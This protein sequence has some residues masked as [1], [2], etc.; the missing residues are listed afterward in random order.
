M[1]YISYYKSKLTYIKEEEK[2]EQLAY[3]DCL[4]HIY[5]RTKCE[6]LMQELDSMLSNYCI[7]SIDLN[8]LKKINDTKGHSMGDWLLSSFAKLLDNFFSV[9]GHT[10]RIGGDEFILILPDDSKY[11]DIDELLTSFILYVENENKKILEFQYS[12][13][14]GYAKRCDVSSPNAKKVYHLAD[15]RMYENK[16]AMKKTNHP[17]S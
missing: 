4:T 5:N 3:H 8:D 2:L 6:Q 15:S 11:K 7:V 9:Y 17:T 13:A 1:G 14:Y 16:I 10:G 12:F